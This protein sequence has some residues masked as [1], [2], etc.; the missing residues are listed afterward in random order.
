MDNSMNQ[1]STGVFI[2][3]VGILFLVL[4]GVYLYM[5]HRKRKMEQELNDDFDESL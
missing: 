2:I 3:E 4:L 5:K 1:F